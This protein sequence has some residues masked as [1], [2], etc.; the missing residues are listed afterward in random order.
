MTVTQPVGRIRTRGKMALGKPHRVLIA[1]DHSLMRDGL[2]SLLGSRHEYT[3]V[4]EASEGLGAIRYAQQL[5]P[6]LV[7]L[8]LS[9]P[10]TNGI[11]ALKEIKRVSAQSRVLV[12][13][14]HK[15]EE[16]IFAALKAGADGYFLKDDDSE[17]LLA[18]LK[19][20]LNGERFLSPTI[21]TKVV[22]GY[23]V[24]ENMAKPSVYELL[25]VREREILKLV[26]EG[27][28]TREIADYL[29][30]SPKTVERHRSNLMK[31]LGL[32]SIAALTSYAI[33]KGLVT[34]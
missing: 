15:D 2:R 30:L 25:S 16:H 33:E 22:A 4:A 3:I 10:G 1:E 14:A 7:L 29:C 19:C 23:L 6:D 5:Q 31:Q 28:R 34:L 11:E 8:D 18:A 21:A 24:M 12:I 17:E 27:K 20:V 9:M 32:H 13:T 26:A